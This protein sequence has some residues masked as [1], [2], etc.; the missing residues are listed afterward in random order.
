L[1]T[2]NTKVGSWTPARFVESFCQ[3]LSFL[4]DTMEAR[5]L[6]VQEKNDEQF[7]G[8]AKSQTPTISF[9][10]TLAKRERD[11]HLNSKILLSR[12][13]VM[14]SHRAQNGSWI[15]WRNVRVRQNQNCET[16]DKQ[17]RRKRQTHAA[18]DAASFLA[19]A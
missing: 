2:D 1:I 9:H 15:L 3:T 14:L 12:T 16:D 13:L 19:S 4:L 17:T 6:A 18:A 7:E 11:E 8:Q 10:A 5:V